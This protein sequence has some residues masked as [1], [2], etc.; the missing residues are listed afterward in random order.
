MQHR[1]ITSTR[2][3]E[4]QLAEAGRGFKL[5]EQ[6]SE[7]LRNW[8]SPFARVQFVCLWMRC[9][10]A[11]LGG[12]AS[13][14][15]HTLDRFGKLHSRGRAANRAVVVVDPITTEPSLDDS[16]SGV[17]RSHVGTMP[18]IVVDAYIVRFRI[19]RAP[20]SQ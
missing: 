2:I 16:F 9:W 14:S 20:L 13:V 7:G 17:Q 4:E 10:D 1:L 6:C 18:I 8:A 12:G 5:P 19:G 11:M 15:Q 3:S